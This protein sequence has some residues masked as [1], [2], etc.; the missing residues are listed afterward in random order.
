MIQ[1]Q[2]VVDFIANIMNVEDGWFHKV[3]YLDHNIIMK[4]YLSN[5]MCN[6]PALSEVDWI[7]R[8]TIYP[9]HN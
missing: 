4:Q 1:Y 3:K 9:D 8:P 6:K 7:V 5:R 2:L